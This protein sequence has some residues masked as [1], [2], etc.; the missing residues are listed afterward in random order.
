VV[1]PRGLI[2]F[3]YRR[4][5]LR[6]LVLTRVEFTLAPGDPAAL[7]TRLTDV[8]AYKKK[9]QPMAEN[10]AGCAFK[11]PTLAAA[12]EGVGAA[13]ARVSAGMLIDRAGCKGLR[14]GS[15]RVS[16]VHGNFLTADAGGRARDVMDLM[17]EVR[18]RVLD[19]FGVVLENEV[20]LWRRSR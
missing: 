12:I 20:V 13:G 7:R 19:R 16:A 6:R 2:D 4:S 5:G 1:F 17:D 3:G 8:M 18:R 11:N 14:L 10:S 15:A 9:S